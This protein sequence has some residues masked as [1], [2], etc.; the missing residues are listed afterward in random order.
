MK[1]CDPNRDKILTTRWTLPPFYYR[2][3]WNTQ[4][5]I[6][7][8]CTYCLWSENNEYGRMWYFFPIFWSPFISRQIKK[9]RHFL[10]VIF[11][12]NINTQRSHQLRHFPRQE[13][14]KKGSK[15][16]TKKRPRRVLSE[17]GIIALRTTVTWFTAARI[18]GEVIQT[19]LRPLD[20]SKS[21]SSND[22]Q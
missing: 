8:V 21:L 20:T 9:L 6:I 22:K 2:G 7:I 16:K 12:I 14:T 3:M 19:S 4:L 15:G 1:L 5:V 10:F 13:E 18:E 11:R 17:K